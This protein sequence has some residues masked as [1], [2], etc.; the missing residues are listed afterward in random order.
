MDKSM[1]TENTNDEQNQ[2][3]SKGT[4]STKLRMKERSR[5]QTTPTNTD[6]N[7][8]EN[9]DYEDIEDNHQ[10]NNPMKKNTDEIKS[11]IDIQVKQNISIRKKNFD[12]FLF[13]RMKKVKYQIIFQK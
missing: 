13:Q 9:L 6:I 5:S 1:D 7:D 2:S 12:H 11:S 3:I 4:L 8:P 10:I